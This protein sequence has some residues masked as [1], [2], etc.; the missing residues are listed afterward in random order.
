MEGC[1]KGRSPSQLTTQICKKSN[2]SSLTAAIM[3]LQTKI[4][5]SKIPWYTLAATEISDHSPLVFITDRTV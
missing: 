5:H 1:Q 4:N 3:K 2:G